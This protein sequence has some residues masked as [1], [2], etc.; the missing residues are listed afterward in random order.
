METTTIAVKTLTT[1]DG[2]HC[3]MHMCKMVVE[4]RSKPVNNNNNKKGQ[5]EKGSNMQR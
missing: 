2:R 5:S 1:D 4:R 3:T